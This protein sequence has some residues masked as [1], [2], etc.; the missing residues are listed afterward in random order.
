ML[1]GEHRSKVGNKNRLAIPKQIREELGDG[2]IITRGY[3]RSLILVNESL[4][5]ELIKS[6]EKRSLLNASVRDIKRY[7]IGGAQKIETDNQGRFVINSSL[8]NFAE[9]N[10]D[11][12]FV[13]IKNWV[14][15]W[16]KAKWENKIDNLSENISDLAD[17]LEEIDK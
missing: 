9:L 3:E 11:L 13:G 17:R 12:I 14:E 7:L 10:T 8:K 4:W 6:V 1:I 5:H 15:I 16:D 2:L